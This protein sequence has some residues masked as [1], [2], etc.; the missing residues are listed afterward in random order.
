MSQLSL[1]SSDTSSPSL[2]EGSRLIS[3]VV[4][5]LD[6][7]FLYACPPSQDD[8]IAVGSLVTVPL[9]KRSATGFV[10]SV[11]SEN[12]ASSLAQ[13]RERG[14]R[15]KQ[16]ASGAAPLQAFSSEHLGFF[17]WIARYYA[18][19]LSK[20]LDLAVP[21][22]APAKLESFLRLRGAAPPDA[23]LGRAQQAILGALSSNESE[24]VPLAQLRQSVHAPAATVRGLVARGLI[25]Q[26]S[27]L[28]A[29]PAFDPSAI[30]LESLR[31]SMTSEQNSAVDAVVGH[32]REGSFASFLLHGVTGSGKTEVYLELM[33]EALKGGRS[34]L[35]VVPEIALTPQLIER[36]E[37][38]LG[39]RVA[40]LHS[41]L[42]PR[43]RWQFWQGLCNGS[44]RVAVGARSALFAP[45][46]DLGAII[47]DEEHD[48]SFKQGE[49]I[50]YHAR[51]LAL[52]RAK[53]ASCPIVLG[54]ATPSL[55]TFHNARSGRHGYLRIAKRFF[56]SPPLA[57]QLVDLNR[58]KPWEMPSRSISAQLLNG[59][60]ETL[61]A[62]EQSFVLYN[63]R[64]FA[65]YLQCS[66]CEHVLG[67][68]HCSVTLTFHRRD[69]SLLCHFCGFSTVPP[70]VCSGCGAR[71]PLP[72][73]GEK[74]DPLF[75]HRGAGTERVAEE[76][77]SLLPE[78]R[79]AQLD[80]DSVRS[81]D[82]YV[83]ILRRVRNREVDILVGTQMI[84][85]G[86]DLPDVTFVG[87]VDCDVGL[88]MPDFRASERSFQLLTQAAGRAGR[89]DK[90]GRVVLQTRVPSHASLQQTVRADYGAF[91]EGELELRKAL[92]YPPFQRLLRII[93]AAEDRNAAQQWA[94]QV[95]SVTA[96]ACAGRGIAVLGPAPA[97]LEKVR[98]LWRYHIVCKAS[99]A[100]LLQGVMQ[101]IKAALADAKQARIVFDLDPQDML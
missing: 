43:E 95:S 14:V 91:A 16:L 30:R 7:E 66:S 94:Q 26:E 35:V 5:P 3:V 56:S 42:S 93:I 33:I 57:H 11:D 68:P 60:A 12:E 32:V 99:S 25:E 45:M 67:C 89:R 10:V 37:R 48:S 1:I 28:P 97:P 79:I 49:G 75:S 36:F 72:V 44:Y 100:S 84:A 83:S 85:K 8:P 96:A 62:G 76:I 41:S 77:A 9:G 53:L 61:K 69:N 64:G 74:A 90:P 58:T 70:L 51:D 87:I 13:M 39:C 29:P 46:R 73:P 80:R 65:S 98:N 23:K 71:E 19:P 17:R 21:P 2:P 101:Q 78:A 54:S 34:A 24:W 27:R 55:E 59:L 38:R 81:I 47:I 86:H 52:V 50:R 4:S 6:G 15:V 18:E 82:D 31:A 92:E 22:P 63:R 20:I 40:L 88:H